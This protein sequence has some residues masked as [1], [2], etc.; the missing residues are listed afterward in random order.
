MLMNPHRTEPSALVK[1]ALTL[2]TVATIGASIAACN[3]EGGTAP[4]DYSL[5]VEATGYSYLDMHILFAA[6]VVPAVIN[7][8][9]FA[10]IWMNHK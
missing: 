9:G 5:V 8:M 10:I 6:N 3:V 1:F 4:M 7:A 2:G